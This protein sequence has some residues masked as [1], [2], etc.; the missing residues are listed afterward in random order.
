MSIER[1][2]LQ[3]EP[4]LLLRFVPPADL[5]ADAPLLREDIVQA[6]QSAGGF[7]YLIS[8]LSLLNLLFPDVVVGMFEMTKVIEDI[9]LYPVLV[10]TS[11]M[12]RLI[13]QAAKQEQYGSLHLPLF[14]TVDE[15]LDHIRQQMAVAQ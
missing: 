10:G 8:D 3:N 15:A 11:D 7:L 5:T 6:A 4:I 14:E 9:D 13:S 12:V 2:T 1:I